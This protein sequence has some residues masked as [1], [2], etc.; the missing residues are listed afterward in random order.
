[1]E[2][3]TFKTIFSTLLGGIIGA[4]IVHIANKR[5]SRMI[6]TFEIFDEAGKKIERIEKSFYNLKYEYEC[7]EDGAFIVYQDK[8]LTDNGNQYSP[9]KQFDTIIEVGTYLNRV[10]FFCLAW[11]V[12]VNLIK[13]TNLWNILKNFVYLLDDNNFHT[14]RYEVESVEPADDYSYVPWKE[15]WKFLY[16]YSQGKLYLKQK[17]SEIFF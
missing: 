7:D 5:R 2:P 3:I 16:D 14:Q 12:N 4:Y 10:A 11:K 15:S 8:F 1:M 9:K 17:I 6:L 13:K